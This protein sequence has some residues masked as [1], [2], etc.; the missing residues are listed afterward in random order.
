M[1]FWSILLICAGMG[2]I[3]GWI[4][5]I[6]LT[7]CVL[8]F[9]EWNDGVDVNWAEQVGYTIAGPLAYLFVIFEIIVLY[10]K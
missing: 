6:P 4:F 5:T 2:G 10:S 7:N 9:C 1:D 8:M 3:M